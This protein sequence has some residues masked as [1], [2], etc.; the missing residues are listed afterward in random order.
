M[1]RRGAAARATTKDVLWTRATQD[2]RQDAMTPLSNR[3]RVHRRSAPPHESVSP[4]LISR[5]GAGTGNRSSPRGPLATAEQQWSGDG[6]KDFR[7]RSLLRRVPLCSPQPHVRGCR[8]RRMTP[9]RSG[10]CRRRSANLADLSEPRT[11]GSRSSPRLPLTPAEQQWEHRVGR[12]TSALPAPSPSC[13][14]QLRL[15][16]CWSKRMTAGRSGL[17]HGRCA[18]FAGCS[19]RS[20]RSTPLGEVGRPHVILLLRPSRKV[21]TRGD[22]RTSARARRLSWNRLVAPVVMRRGAQEERGEAAFTF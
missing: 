1:R 7:F 5:R 12:R 17:S 20:T 11:E 8:S 2:Y 13:S 16:G 9:G 4:S 10:L 15:R 22:K 18:K 6:S 14:P 3:R 21:S 19:S